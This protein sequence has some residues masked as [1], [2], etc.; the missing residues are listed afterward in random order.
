[1][2]EAITA[3]YERLSANLALE[4]RLLTKKAW[5]SVPDQPEAE[6]V[7]ERVVTR[8]PSMVFAE[9]ISQKTAVV[10]VGGILYNITLTQSL[11]SDNKLGP[12]PDLATLKPMTDPNELLYYSGKAIA[13][14][15]A[16]MN[17]LGQEPVS[18]R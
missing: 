17:K 15:A 8:L 1:M 10:L 14:L 2:I 6:F 11:S 7:E 12:R 3:E 4:V 9:N 18:A 5:D 13:A 16:H